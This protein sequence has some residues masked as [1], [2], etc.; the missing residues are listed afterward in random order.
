MKTTKYIPLKAAS[1][2][3]PGRPHLATLHRWTKKGV[4][5]VKLRTWRVG[6]RVYTTEAALD[7]FLAELNKTDA[8]RLAEEGC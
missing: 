4:N 5:G 1:A 8:E 6:N 3:L 7:D 2:K